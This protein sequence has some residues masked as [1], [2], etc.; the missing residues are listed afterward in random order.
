MNDKTIIDIT[1]LD[2]EKHAENVTKRAAAYSEKIIHQA[3]IISEKEYQKF[4]LERLEKD[5]GFV[6]RKANN[7]D[8]YYAIDREMLFKFL[9]DTQAETM[10]HLRKI[11]KNDLEETIISFIN[12]ETTK[13]RGS[14]IEVL[15]HGIEL[16]N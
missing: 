3:S 12:S 13:K 11:Y 8:R 10:D 15:K 9:C 6:V 5:N 14:L 7:F 1:K 4:L 2:A 16:S